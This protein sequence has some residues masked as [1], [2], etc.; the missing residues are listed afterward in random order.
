MDERVEVGCDQV[1]RTR[2]TDVA[3]GQCKYKA[4]IVSAAVSSMRMEAIDN[5]LCT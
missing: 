5:S 1:G 4:R 2:M 3:W